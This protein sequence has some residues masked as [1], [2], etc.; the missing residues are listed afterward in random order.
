MKKEYFLTTILLYALS[1]FFCRCSLDPDRKLNDAIAR[2]N[3]KQPKALQTLENEFISTISVDSV[4]GSNLQS[5]GTLL[6]RIQDK[7]VEIAYPSTYSFTLTDGETIRHVDL[8][9][10]YAVI[11]DGLQFCIYDSDGD[12]RNDETI[13]DKKNQV[14]ALVINGDDI[15]Y[16]KQF[17]IY[18]YSIIHNSSDQILKEI[19]QPPYTNY[20][21]VHLYKRDDLLA[22]LAGIAGSYNFS[23]INLSNG[24]IILKKIGMS[25]SKHHLGDNTIRYITGNSGNWEL[26][27][28]SL[29]SKTKK[30]LTRLTD[31]IDIELTGQGYVIHSATG[32][33][34]S[35]YGKE[36]IRIPFS[37]ELAGKYKGRILFAYKDKYYFTDMKKLI[38]GLKK[39]SEKTPDLFLK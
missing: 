23:I 15:I 39:L 14:K 21:M 3:D 26:I 17:K 6:Y 7:D 10:D 29:D 37:Y 35:E 4:A 32:L 13:G 19:F 20:Y 27:Q 18:R 16:Y 28:Y 2:Y 38:T 9:G 34:A 33:W 31:I 12:H 30:S 11:S 36:R 8:R 24:A 22:V 1:L 25:S 5:N